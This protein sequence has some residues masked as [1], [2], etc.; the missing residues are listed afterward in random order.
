MDPTKVPALA[1]YNAIAQSQFNGDQARYK[2]DWAASQKFENTL[3]LDKAWRKEQI[4]LN[5]IY[6]DIAQKRAEFINKNGNSTAAVKDGYKR[7]PI[8]EYDVSTERWIKT[9]PMNI[10]DR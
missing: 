10:Y 9:K 4:R 5:N 3:Q 8:P 6:G 7:Y 2:G 1:G